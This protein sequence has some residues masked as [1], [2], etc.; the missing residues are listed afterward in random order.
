MC[1][2]QALLS[3]AGSKLVLSHLSSLR[4][5]MFDFEKSATC[6]HEDV[7]TCSTNET[8]LFLHVTTPDNA[9]KK[10]N[11]DDWVASFGRGNIIWTEYTL[12]RIILDYYKVKVIMHAKKSI[13]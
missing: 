11:I 13:C 4:F 5:M 6:T 1:I 2:E 9:A 12:Y 7:D 8:L 3:T 10:R